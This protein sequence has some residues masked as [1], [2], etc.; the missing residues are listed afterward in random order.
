MCGEAL[1]DA[2]EILA[3]SPVDFNQPIDIEVSAMYRDTFRRLLVLL[4]MMQMRIN[5]ILLPPRQN[6]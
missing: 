2:W 3:S 5:S 6:P 1:A 4:D